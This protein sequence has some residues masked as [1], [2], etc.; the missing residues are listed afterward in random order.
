MTVTLLPISR[1]GN[2]EDGARYLG[3]HVNDLSW[4]ACT[5]PYQASAGRQ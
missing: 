3:L 2:E 1:P 5:P 4:L